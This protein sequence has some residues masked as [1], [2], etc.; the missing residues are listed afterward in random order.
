MPGMAQSHGLG[1]VFV[2]IALCTDATYVLAEAT[3][4]S[5]I[6]GYLMRGVPLCGGI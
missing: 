2:L 3:V 5:A 6:M 4:P 1:T